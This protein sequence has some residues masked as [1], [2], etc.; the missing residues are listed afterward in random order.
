MRFGFHL[1]V[2]GGLER[3][4]REAA[5]L[6]LDC[7]QVFATSPRTW[8]QRRIGEAEAERFQERC[9]AAGL[10]PVV[11]HA[12]Y[13]LNLASPE[14]VLWR[15]SISALADQLRRAELIGA[16]GVVVHP[17][18]R[19]GRSLDWGL[20]RVAR[21]VERALERAAPTRA[22][23]WLEN[24]AGGRGQMGGTLA[25]LA[26]LASRL[27]GWPVGFCLDT[28]HAWGAGYHLE[29]ARAVERFLRR[30]DRLLGLG[31]VRLWHFNDSAC[32]RGSRRDRHQHLGQGGIGREGFAALV[33]H[34]SLAQAPAVMETPKDSPQADRRNLALVRRL[35]GTGAS[36][37]DID[38]YPALC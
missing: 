25:Q 15:R 38:S 7:L 24:T 34:P 4:A 3:A 8:R 9:R 13:L 23:V 28:A 16:A 20:E 22:E 21:A 33:R 6:G 36:G 29:H 1:S 18:S 31:R 10:A 2:A 26:W 35:E 14:P 12:P 5:A 17:G 11:I 27:Q 32:P 37:R 19:G 30:V